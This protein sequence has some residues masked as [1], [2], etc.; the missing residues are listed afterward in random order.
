MI[1]SPDIGLEAQLPG[2]GANFREALY[3]D[4]GGLEDTG[5]IH[6]VVYK[7]YHRA[8]ARRFPFAVFYTVSDQT[9]WVQAVVDCRREPTWITEHLA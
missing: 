5:G 7:N 2:L 8:L 6:R 4:I 9:V 3:S 1:L